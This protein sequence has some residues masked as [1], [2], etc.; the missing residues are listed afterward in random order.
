M[1]YYCFVNRNW[2]P[3]QYL[4]LPDRERLLVSLFVKKEAEARDNALRK[5]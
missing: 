1:A 2:T 4:E 3:S 5:K